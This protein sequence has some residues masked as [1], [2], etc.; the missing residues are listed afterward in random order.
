MVFGMGLWDLNILPEKELHSRVW[1]WLLQGLAGIVG[2]AGGSSGLFTQAHILAMRA[3]GSRSDS[4]CANESCTYDY[5]PSTTPVP[6]ALG[7]QPPTCGHP[8]P[9]RVTKTES[10]NARR[11]KPSTGPKPPSTSALQP[12]KYSCRSGLRP[13]QD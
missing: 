8:L 5:N 9:Y 2:G 3:R 7:A 13:A 6:D 12:R 10:V 4:S 1:V 11:A